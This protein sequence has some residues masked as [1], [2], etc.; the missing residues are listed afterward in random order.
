MHC[1]H[2][3]QNLHNFIE[4]TKAFCHEVFSHTVLYTLF[5]EYFLEDAIEMVG[6]VP[7]PNN[8]KKKKSAGPEAAEEEEEV[9]VM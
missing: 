2:T 3:D 4:F 8:K 9:S 1:Q 7:P 5:A 6:F